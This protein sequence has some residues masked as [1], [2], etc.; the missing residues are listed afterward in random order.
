M[1]VYISDPSKLTTN[2]ADT[3]PYV[4]IRSTGKVWTP[5]VDTSE[6]WVD[7]YQEEPKT[8][9]VLSDIF[10]NWDGATSNAKQTLVSGWNNIV[11]PI[12]RAF[13]HGADLSA[14]TYFR[15]FQLPG[16]TYN[17]VEW[18]FD[19]IRIVDWTEFERCDN[20]A[21]WRDRP[22]Q[23]NQYQYVND[24]QGQAEGVSCIAC[25]DVLIT[26]VNSYRLE[27]WPGL[28]YAM[29]AMYDQNDL[30]LQ[31]KFYLDEKNV[32]WFNKWIHFRVELGKKGFRVLD[33]TLTPPAWKWGFTPDNNCINMSVGVTGDLPY[34]FKA[35][36]QTITFNFSDYAA[37]ITGDFNIRQLGYLRVI[38]TPIDFKPTERESDHVEYVTY[39]LDDIRI[40]KK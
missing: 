10:S 2:T 35:G 26:T 19:Q 40:L 1:R 22:A 36:W 14:I 16:Y 37:K 24:T 7:I 23:E 33:D 28:E 4:E 11:L 34:T 31:L 25:E 32:A 30:K 20:F 12:D 8:R 3:Q 21:M 18:R 38:L 27:M 39:K 17:E 29:P 13:V 6:E 5:D 15:I 9:W